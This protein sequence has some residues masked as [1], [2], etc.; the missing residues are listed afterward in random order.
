MADRRDGFFSRVE[1]AHDF[2]QPG[3]QAQVFRR[4]AAG[5]HQARVVG[6]VDLVEVVVDDE[7]VAALFSVGLVALKVMDGGL[8]RVA[9]LFAGADGVHFIAHHLEHLKGHHNLVIFHKISGQQQNLFH[10]LYSLG[11]PRQGPPRMAPPGP[12]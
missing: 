1:F 2:Q 3:V 9:G 6:G 5:H 7:I 11:M 10:C 12:G 4:A 8:H